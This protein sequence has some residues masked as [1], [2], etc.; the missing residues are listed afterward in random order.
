MKDTDTF[1]SIFRIIGFSIFFF[2]LVWWVMGCAAIRTVG[3][4]IEDHNRRVQE[5]I[6]WDETTT[7]FARMFPRG[8]QDTDGG[9]CFQGTGLLTKPT[10]RYQEKIQDALAKYYVGE[11]LVL[12]S[13]DRVL[14]HEYTHYIIDVMQPSKSCQNELAARAMNE[15][16][17][18]RRQI[19]LERQ[20]YLDMQ[21]HVPIGGRN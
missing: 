6:D 9:S 18:L 5:D 21:R 8:Y 17:W 4:S 10:V 13:T 16:V 3:L 1:S 20:R 12:Y 15:V 11:A 2:V 7:E 19:M 14:A